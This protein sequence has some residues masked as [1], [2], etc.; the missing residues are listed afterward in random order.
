MD[1]KWAWRSCGPTRQRQGPG[2]L[3][4]HRVVFQGQQRHLQIQLLV[5][6]CRRRRRRCRGGRG[7]T[8]SGELRAAR[9]RVAP[10]DVL[11]RRRRGG[12]AAG[13]WRRMRGCRRRQTRASARARARAHEPRRRRQT[14]W[15]RSESEPLASL[16]LLAR[17]REV[18]EAGWHGPWARVAHVAACLL[19]LHQDT[20]SCVVWR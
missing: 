20:L 19:L 9:A 1:V 11:D 3:R 7:V 18:A 10:A 15:T 2:N 13:R 5:C 16:R 6:P 4:W 14:G 8:D 17:A 12:G